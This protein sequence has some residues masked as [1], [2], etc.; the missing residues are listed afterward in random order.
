MIPIKLNEMEFRSTDACFLSF[1]AVIELMKPELHGPR[2][3][4]CGGIIESITDGKTPEIEAL[5][6]LALWTDS[7]LLL[8]N[9][10]LL[11][12]ST[13]VDNVMVDNEKEEWAV[14]PEPMTGTGRP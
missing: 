14:E 11:S 12:S 6:E 10:H 7:G 3:H 9:A 5:Q 1:Q 8:N 4:F 2:L 13:A